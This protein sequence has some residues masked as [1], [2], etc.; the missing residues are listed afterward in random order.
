M[1]R[2]K[3]SKDYPVEVKREAIRLFFEEGWTKADITEFLDIRDP[4]RVGNWL[5]RY[6]K[7]GEGMFFHKRRGRP[8]KKE[9]Q[10]AYIARLE[11]ENDLLKKY[12]AEL[13]KILRERRDIGASNMSSDDTA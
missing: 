10:E 7:E 6:R 4:R 12:H 5:W 2:N 1:A 11:M 13:R 9:N 3:G 8:P